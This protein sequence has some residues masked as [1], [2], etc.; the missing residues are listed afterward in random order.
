MIRR[1]KNICTPFDI[2]V[3]SHHNRL[4]GQVTDALFTLQFNF[5]GGATPPCL[6]ACDSNGDGSVIGTVTDA[7]YTLQHNFLDGPA[8]VAPFPVCGP[9]ELVTDAGLGCET[10]LSDCQTP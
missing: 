8:P 4:I 6:A 7:L 10:G 3:V 1:R 5:L 9:R 2:S